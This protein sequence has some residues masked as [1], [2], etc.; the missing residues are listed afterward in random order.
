MRHADIDA[1]LRSAVASGAA[2]GVVA[3]A[4]NADGIFYEGAC[5]VGDLATQAPIAI[6]SVFQL[7]SMTKAVTSVAAM[8]LVEQGRIGLNAPIAEMLPGLAAPNVLAGFAPDGTPLLRPARGTITLRHLLTHTAGFGYDTWNAEVAPAH[9]ALGLPR[10]PVTAEQHART[11]L[12]YDPGTRWNYSIAT[13]LVGQAVEAVSGQRLDAYMQDNIFAP[14]GMVDTGFEMTAS[15]TAR[16]AQLHARA[17]DGTL[18]PLDLD[19]GPYTG[20][21]GG[22]GLHGTAR[23]YFRFLQMLLNHGRLHGTTILR[24]ETVAAMGRNQIGEINGEPMRSVVPAR[25]NEADFFPG[26]VQKWGLGFL[27]NTETTRSG[28]SPGGLCWAGLRNTYYWIDPTRGIAG[29]LLTQILPFADPR[30][31]DMLWAFERAVYAAE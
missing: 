16:K 8:Q 19:A 17:A 18:T 9:T 29:V 30:V 25:S 10:V 15:Q 24:P 5:G 31:L 28:R 14:L 6:D 27:I 7:A 20:G 12:L 11:P 2:P 13:D 26:M 21:G 1:V 23:D 3:L 22:G 4:G